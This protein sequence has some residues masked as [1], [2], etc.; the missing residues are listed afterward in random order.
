MLETFSQI[1]NTKHPLM[2]PFDHLLT[3][4]GRISLFLLS[5]FFASVQDNTF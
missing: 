4:V 2:K 3:I 1:L 5:V